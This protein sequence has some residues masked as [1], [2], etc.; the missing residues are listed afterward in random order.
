MKLFY[1]LIILLI[2]T[3]FLSGCGK[4]FFK[5]SDVKDNPVNVEERVARNVEEGR[6]VRFAFGNKKSATTYENNHLL[7]DSTLKTKPLD[8]HLIKD[9]IVRVR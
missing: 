3:V 7:A 5:R 6:G 4:G 9:N 8:E 1:Q 2:L